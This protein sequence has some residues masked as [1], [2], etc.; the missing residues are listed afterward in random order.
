MGWTFVSTDLRK[1]GFDKLK[2]FIYVNKDL[3]HGTLIKKK[4]MDL[5]KKEA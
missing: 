2:V 5:E 1:V 3:S 4:K